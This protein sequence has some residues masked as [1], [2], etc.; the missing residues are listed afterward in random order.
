[1]ISR[2]TKQK[3]LTGLLVVLPF[4]LTIIILY[5]LGK[6]MIEKKRVSKPLK[7]ALYVALFFFFFVAFIYLYFPADALTKRI[8]QEIKNRTGLNVEAS[9]ADI[10][11]PADI[12]LK[13]VKLIDKRK[14]TTLIDELRISP[15]LLSV[16]K[17]SGSISFEAKIKDGRIEG[18]AEY[19]KG[20][21][22][23]DYL[24]VKTDKVDL[25]AL[26]ELLKI[27]N[28]KD[29]PDIDGKINGEFVA[30][31]DPKSSSRGRFKLS[32]EKLSLSGLKFKEFPLPDFKDLKIDVKGR[33]K[34]N[35]TNLES[36][37]AENKELL[38]VLNGTAPLPWKIKKENLDLSVNLKLKPG[39]QLGF[40]KTF[41][42]KEKD[43][44]ISVKVK[45]PLK[46]LRFE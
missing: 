29:V 33:M 39:T 34:K 17:Q 30:S 37:R 36:F 4:G 7:Y 26:S 43:G 9:S 11:P 6:L 22:K 12:K 13:N 1:M 24:V 19:S 40:L 31:F 25:K 27:K 20:G 32:S 46:N 44:I 28:I 42:K 2:S 14:K 18:V 23:L 21:K 15:S 41:A 8:N 5:Q 16:F 38:L 45:G 35:R 3:I 10:F